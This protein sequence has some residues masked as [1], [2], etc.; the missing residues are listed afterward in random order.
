MMS[1]LPKIGRDD[2]AL[3]LN[4]SQSRFG[5][6]KPCAPRTYWIATQEHPRLPPHAQ[7]QIFRSLRIQPVRILIV[8][9]FS[10]TSHSGESLADPMGFRHI[11]E[12]GPFAHHFRDRTTHIENDKIGAS[13]YTY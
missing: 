6:Y 13:F 3:R 11:G 1:P 7:L 4:K 5:R 9:E 2:L 10:R 12:P 8:T